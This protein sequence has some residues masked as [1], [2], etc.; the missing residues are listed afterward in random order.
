[1]ECAVSAKLRFLALSVFVSV[2]CATLFVDRPAMQSGPVI[3]T[4]VLVPMRDG[5]RLAA[6]VYRP[7]ASGRFPVLLSRT[8]YNK[9]GQAALAK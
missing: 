1:M 6:D 9:N 2:M 8:P 4:N 7:S 5:V 3:E